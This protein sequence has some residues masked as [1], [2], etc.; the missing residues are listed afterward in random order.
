LYCCSEHYVYKPVIIHIRDRGGTIENRKRRSSIRVSLILA[1]SR[2][3]EKFQRHGPYGRVLTRA[4]E[5]IVLGA[6]TGR[7][8]MN[9]SVQWQH[10]V[11]CDLVASGCYSIDILPSC[12]TRVNT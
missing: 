6:E 10:V 4:E 5:G 1:R 8:R 12:V 3:K 11:L 9:E 7:N 2:P